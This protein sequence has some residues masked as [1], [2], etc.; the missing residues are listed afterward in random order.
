MRFPSVLALPNVR[1][2]PEANRS[3]DPGSMVRV[4]VDAEETLIS[5]VTSYG[6]PGLG[7]VKLLATVP[8]TSS[9]AW[10]PLA[11]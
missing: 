2:V 9:M 8:P 4:G 7:N 11:V 3:V 6:I 5:L 10:V 1:P